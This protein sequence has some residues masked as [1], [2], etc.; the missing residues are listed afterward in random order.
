[1]MLILV[2]MLTFMGWAIGYDLG[3]Q[4]EDAA[5]VR[6]VAD[7]DAWIADLRAAFAADDEPS[8][9]RR[10]TVRFISGVDWCS[11]RCTC[12]W[13]AHGADRAEVVDS[14]ERHAHATSGRII[15]TGLPALTAA[16]S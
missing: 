14:A 16:T 4:A 13:T 8:I 5:E 11:A 1:M 10:H 12:L 3:R 9:I 2:A 6:D 15:T 7:A